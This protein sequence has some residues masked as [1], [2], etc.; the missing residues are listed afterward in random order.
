MALAAGALLAGCRGDDGDDRAGDRDG[1][2]GPS[3]GAALVERLGCESGSFTTASGGGWQ[4]ADVHECHR[5][6]L[7]RVYGSLTPEQ[8]D[9]AV[10]LLAMETGDDGPAEGCAGLGYVED[11]YVVAGGTWVAVV[12]GEDEAATAA[13]RLDGDVQPGSI[14][15]PSVTGGFGEPCLPGS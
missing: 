14:T 8:R 1:S 7:A 13:E 10:R 15:T 11:L 5:G 12:Q 9:A 4:E 6:V 3:A 2:A